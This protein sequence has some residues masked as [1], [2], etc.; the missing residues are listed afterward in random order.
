MGNVALNIEAAKQLTLN[1]L[2]RRKSW[3]H[4]RF[5]SFIGHVVEVRALYS[6][7][8]AMLICSVL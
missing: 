5:G 4:C 2:L 3:I 8:G 6:K 1:S 7:K